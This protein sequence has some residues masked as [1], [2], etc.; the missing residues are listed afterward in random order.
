MSQN[1]ERRVLNRMGARELTN[2][3]CEQVQGAIIRTGLCSIHLNSNG[4]CSIDGDCEPPPA[5]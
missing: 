3:E 1:A 5:C 4:T 2:H